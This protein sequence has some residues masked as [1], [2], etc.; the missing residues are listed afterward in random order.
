[1]RRDLRESTGRD[2][3]ETGARAAIIGVVG[4]LLS[5]VTGW[6]IVGPVI[7]NLVGVFWSTPK[8]RAQAKRIVELERQIAW[9]NSSEGDRQRR[10]R[11]AR[12]RRMGG[13]D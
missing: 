13:R 6:P 8:E 4:G 3:A 1:V 12:Y 10:K 9:T 5:V 11:D 2:S 7:A